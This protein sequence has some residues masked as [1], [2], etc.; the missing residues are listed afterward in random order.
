MFF[1]QRGHAFIPLADKPCTQLVWKMCMQ[2]IT[3]H[4]FPFFFF[5]KH[6]LQTVCSFSSSWCS[7]HGNVFTD[8]LS[9]S[10]SESEPSISSFSLIQEMGFEI[11]S[12][13][14]LKISASYSRSSYLLLHSGFAQDILHVIQQLYNLLNIKMSTLI[15]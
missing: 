8:S 10:T 2:E 14:Y 13:Q 5:S 6:I 7:S 4:R 9:L 1:L 11:W 12:K 15:S 3:Q